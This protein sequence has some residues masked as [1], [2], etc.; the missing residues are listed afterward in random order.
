MTED[1]GRNVSLFLV[2]IFNAAL[3]AAAVSVATLS[4]QGGEPIFKA[5]GIYAET[6]PVTA[7]TTKSFAQP[8]KPKSAVVS[9]GSRYAEYSPWYEVVGGRMVAT[10]DRHL[11]DEHGVPQSEL[12]GLSQAEKDRLHGK[13]HG[14]KPHIALARQPVWVN[15]AVQN[16]PGGQCPTSGLRFTRR[17]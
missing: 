11:T 2:W 6:L 8:E 3:I 5:T 7:S 12:I 14:E 15:N 13:M 4:A 17:R 16:C 1:R 9:N 10:S